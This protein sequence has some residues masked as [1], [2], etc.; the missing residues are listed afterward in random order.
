MVRRAPGGELL[1]S[2]ASVG[3]GSL[4]VIQNAVPE[5][6]NIGQVGSEVRLSELVGVRAVRLRWVVSGL[7]QAYFWL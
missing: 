5:A 4:E 2:P 1:K 3:T 6:L 7:G